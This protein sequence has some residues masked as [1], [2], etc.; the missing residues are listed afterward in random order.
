MK[1]PAG[2]FCL[3]DAVASLAR[4]D[5][6]AFDS[7][8]FHFVGKVFNFLRNVSGS[9]SVAED[10]TQ[11]VFIKV[12]QKREGLDPDQNFEAWLFVC[13][14]NLVLNEFRR[15]GQDSE[16]LRSSKERVHEEDRSTVETIDYHFAEQYMAAIV[17]EMPPQRRKIFLLSR[18]YGL[19]SA[20][21]AGQLGISPRSVENQLYQARKYISRRINEKGQ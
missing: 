20:E 21:I 8:Y 3:R 2:P 19:S 11:E 18:V 16:F 12:W 15:R 7:I 14:R 17:N 5:R 10:L 6:E 9:D 13:A 4:G 1:K